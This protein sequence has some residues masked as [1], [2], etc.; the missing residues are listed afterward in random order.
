MTFYAVCS[1][2]RSSSEAVPS[3]SGDRAKLCS[4]INNPPAL[5]RG[6]YRGRGCLGTGRFAP[7]GSRLAT[8]ASNEMSLGAP[9]VRFCGWP[10]H[11]GCR[12]RSTMPT[13]RFGLAPMAAPEPFL[14]LRPFPCT[15]GHGRLL[16]PQWEI[17]SHGQR[18]TWQCPTPPRRN[19]PPTSAPSCEIIICL[20]SSL[21][22]TSIVSAP[23]ITSIDDNE[24]SLRN[25]TAVGGGYI[26]L[27]LKRAK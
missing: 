2:S 10:R 12:S 23:V 22:R 20:G 6:A 21:R 5:I 11:L 18:K 24:L 26:D 13:G 16:P 1:L 4:S 19:V 17:P 9:L 14:W 15:P 7:A 3:C 25:P 8:M 27:V